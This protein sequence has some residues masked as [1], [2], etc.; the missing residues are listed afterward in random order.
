LQTISMEKAVFDITGMTCSACS[1]RIEKGIAKLEGIAE[2]SVNLLT[3]SMAVTFD[4]KQTST[5]Q[6]AKGV[7]DIGYGAVVKT[8]ATKKQAT[9]PASR[10]QSEMQ[11][12]KNRLIV[13]L[14]FTVSLFYISM[15]VMHRWPMPGF[16]SGLENA[17]FSRS[18]CFC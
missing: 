1:A 15:G 16:L 2:V 13:S 8:A 14:I 10:A 5:N 3:N 18:H 11:A 17:W 6:I 4:A 9:Q 7:E 12:M